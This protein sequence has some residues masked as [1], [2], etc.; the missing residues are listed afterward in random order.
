MITAKMS[1]PVVGRDFNPDDLKPPTAEDLSAYK[2]E[3]KI[4]IAVFACTLI[5]TLYNVVRFVI[6]QKR[7]KNW[8][9]FAFYFF[10]VFVLSF[11]ILYYIEVLYFFSLL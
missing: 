6:C 4:M 7:Y 11:R 1:S 10:S 3:I 2:I 9:I 8:L 5:F